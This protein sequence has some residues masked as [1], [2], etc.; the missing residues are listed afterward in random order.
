MT[1]V[2]AGIV[3]LFLSA[4]SQSA[5]LYGQTAISRTPAVVR[6]QAAV[7]ILEKAAAAAGGKVA[8]RAFQDFAATGIMTYP[9][10]DSSVQGEAEIK[11]KSPDQVRIDVRLPDRTNSI[12]IS[13]GKGH[14]SDASGSHE[15]SNQNAKHLGFL[16]FAQPV[17]VRALDDPQTGISVEEGT[18][19]F[20]GSLVYRI[21]ITQPTPSQ[22]LGDQK[23]RRL[24]TLDVLIDQTTLMIVQLDHPLVVDNRHHT[25]RTRQVTFSDFRN[26]SGIVVPF[27]IEETEA[28][29]HVSTLQ[30]STFK[31]NSGVAA[32]DFD[33]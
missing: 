24:R 10:S 30:L 7:T 9:S 12:I 28:T 33:Q 13:H 16:I 17:L 15:I 20:N 21:H 3:L 32:T 25:V 14:V 31:L 11:A 5:A 4:F 6:D 23:L 18:E 8:I 27:V 22:L 19:N 26:I 29:Q 2:R 1:N